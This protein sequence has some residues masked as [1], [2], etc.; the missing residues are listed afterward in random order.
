LIRT[1][2]GALLGLLVLYAGQ[3]RSQPAVWTVHGPRGEVVLFGSVHLLP[4][5]LDWRTPALDRALAEAAD[6]W[7]ELPLG[8]T[9]DEEARRLSLRRSALPPGDSL[10][11]HL[12]ATQRGRIEQAAAQVGIP[13]A[14]LTR[15]QPWMAE[16][17]LSLASDAHAGA[18]VAEGVETRLQANA[19]PTAQ[20][21]ALETVR[22]QIAV[23]ADASLGDQIASLDETAQ[24]MTAD[25]YLYAKIVRDWMTA[26]LVALQHDAL[27]P[28]AAVA[29]AS[30][31]RLIV[32]RNVRWARLLARV[33]RN[34]R[35]VAVVVV[36]AGHL[37][38][39]A[40]VPSLL[41]ARGFRVDGP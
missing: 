34:Q 17:S 38:G 25:P 32:D 23:L 24:E 10:W 15:L 27:D 37:I 35:G 14:A 30:Y 33:A 7:F 2:A 31:R 8:Q 3:V 19:P 11:T 6:L 26:D 36:G 39:P 28:M 4:E 1:W 12:T 5:G 40:G 18:V 16:V 13:P 20:R 9:T 29:P 41:R 22:Q 21:H